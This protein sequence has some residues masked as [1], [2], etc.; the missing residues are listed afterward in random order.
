[1]FSLSSVPWFLDK[2]K[3]APLLSTS[4]VYSVIS[5]QPQHNL[6]LDTPKDDGTLCTKDRRYVREGKLFVCLKMSMLQACNWLLASIAK[7]ISVTELRVDIWRV[8]SHGS[9]MDCSTVIVCTI[10]C[11]GGTMRLFV[12][13][14]HLFWHL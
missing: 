7:N 8:R 2:K 1:M 5:L 9:R 13:S 4:S 3:N 14:S 6:N 11:L 12:S 10:W